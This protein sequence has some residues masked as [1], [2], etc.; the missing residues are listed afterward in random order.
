M[1]S[2][3]IG[4]GPILCS[5]SI[6]TDMLSAPATQILSMDRNVGMTTTAI[7]AGARRTL[8]RR[9]LTRLRMVLGR[10]GR[11]LRQQTDGEFP[12]ALI[13]LLCTIERSEPVTAGGLPAGE[14]GAPPA[15]TRPLRGR[16][17][18]RR[19]RRARPP[20]PRRAPDIPAAAAGGRP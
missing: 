18:D 2:S 12:Y 8:N 7:K 19:R 16:V 20:R 17:R 11:V 6:P 10:L 14:R 5:G 13:S 9:D 4:A 1:T 3:V 15:G